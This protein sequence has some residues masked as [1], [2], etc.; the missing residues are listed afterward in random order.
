MKATFTEDKLKKFSEKKN[1]Y[2]IKIRPIRLQYIYYILAERYFTFWKNFFIKELINSLDFFNLIL[3][4]E[5]LACNEVVLI[6]EENKKEKKKK[7]F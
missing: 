2:S 5:T 4:G 7:T 6:L 1:I 3:I